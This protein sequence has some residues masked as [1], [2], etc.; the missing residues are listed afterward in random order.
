[1]R[2]YRGLTKDG[3]WVYG[4]YIKSGMG[5]HY[6]YIGKEGNPIWDIDGCYI[7]V[8]PKTVGQSTGKFDIKNKEVFAGDISRGHGVLVYTE[9]GIEG[10]T[11]FYWKDKEGIHHYEYLTTPVEI[12]SNIHEK[13]EL[14]EK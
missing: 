4:W 3:K 6:I 8:I 11:G 12:I 1:M 7:K 9:D 14:L 5:H 2:Q 10:T 13:Q